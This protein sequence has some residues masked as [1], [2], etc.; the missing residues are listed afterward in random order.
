VIRTS[1][2]GAFLLI[3][4]G[5]GPA[6]AQDET[7]YTVTPFVGIFL[8]AADLVSDQV[9]PN[10]GPLDPERISMGHQAGLVLGV[11]GSISLG[12]RTWLEIEFQ[13]ASSDVKITAT[14]REPLP[15]PTK[16]GGAHVLTLGADV[17]WE[18]FRAPFTPFAIH[19]LGG[20]ASVNRGGEF[21][22]QGGRFFSALDGGTSV[23]AILGLGFRYGFSPR[24]GIRVDVRDYI[25]SY[26]QSLP[27]GKLDSQLQNDIWITGGLELTL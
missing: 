16:T 6:T 15:E 10:P 18:L 9:V 7:M 27:G 19:L 24:L 1:L 17:F 26:T 11:R 25:S 8:P 2:R 5:A 20:L 14:R 3:L 12:S 4:A 22:D 13:Y 23:A 21:F